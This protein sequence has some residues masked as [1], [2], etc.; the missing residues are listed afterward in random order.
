MGL[1]GILNASELRLEIASAAE[2]RVSSAGQRRSGAREFAA[3]KT[4][5]SVFPRQVIAIPKRRV[6]RLEVR[7]EA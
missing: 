5:M 6:P 3:S 1:A 7:A 4:R 2:N